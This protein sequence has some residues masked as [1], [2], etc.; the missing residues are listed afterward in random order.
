MESKELI[1]IGPCEWYGRNLGEHSW[2]D[3]VDGFERCI[4]MQTG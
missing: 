1:P 4:K 3:T 2:A